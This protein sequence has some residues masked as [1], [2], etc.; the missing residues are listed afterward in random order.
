MPWAALLA[1]ATLLAGCG[2]N[3]AAN[4]AASA[5]KP[6]AAVD[7]P[8]DPAVAA[9]QKRTTAALT[10]GR[11]VAPVELRFA[12]ATPPAAGQPVDVELALV[13]QVAVPT[14][15]VEV[16]GAAD[17]QLVEPASP[18]SLE[19]VQAGTLHTIPVRAVPARDGTT[20]LTVAVT[21][22]QPTG[23]ESRTFQLPLVVGAGAAPPAA[24]PA[25][26]GG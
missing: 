7:V 1:G 17:V 24:A 6:A 8:V 14:V 22:Q 5:A 18:V 20:T 12:V 26:A 23:P 10:V 16:K 25:P 15:R 3:E 2:G 9:A 13:T 21:L 19:K 4:T 11:S